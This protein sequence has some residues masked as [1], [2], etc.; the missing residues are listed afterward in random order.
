MTTVQ[1]TRRRT[2]G[3]V[4]AGGLFCARLAASPCLAFMAGGAFG[5]DGRLA[6]EARVSPPYHLS[7]S[8]HARRQT[9]YLFEEYKRYLAELGATIDDVVQVE[10]YLQSKAHADG[11]LTVSRAA[12]NLDH[13]RPPSATVV[14]GAALPPG[15]VV[16]LV[17]TAVLPG[18]W[19]KEI[20]AS[21]DNV[22]WRPEW[23]DSY[24]RPLYNRI[25]VAGPYVFTVGDIAM[26]DGEP[27]HP[28]ARLPD[29]IWWGDEMRSE[30]THNMRRFDETL[31]LAGSSLDQAVRATVMMTDPGD[32]N[33][34]DLVWR[35]AFPDAPPARTIVPIRA[36]CSPRKEIA[37]GHGENA[38]RYESMFQSIR[39][40][41]GVEKE[42]IS[43]GAETLG[44]SS[45]A[46]RT[47]DL[48]WISGQLAAH[49]RDSSS[50]PDIRLEL[51][52]IFE[53]LDAICRA[54]G[55]ELSNLLQLRAFVTDLADGY[56]V[57]ATLKAVVEDDPPT[58]LI[59]E[60]PGP[61]I[62]PGCT[63]TVDGVAYVPPPSAS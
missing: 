41:F 36:V 5:P 31:Q 62:L 43:T 6:E 2:L 50:G 45:E 7:A 63:V 53:R 10:Q 29:W 15:S 49:V 56:A 52:A 39:P 18:E 4:D 44:Y 20:I 25:A 12:G 59:T 9:A 22:K 17:T 34:L 55:T 54:G 14:S 28:A 42:M 35:D 32:L 1:D 23:G 51:E 21:T 24:A 38:L 47:G 27:I 48:L 33:E 57:H 26:G 11:Y 3:V 40:G 8:A 13:D 46:V 30:A 19:R 61:M 37:R 60:V 58:V 16:D